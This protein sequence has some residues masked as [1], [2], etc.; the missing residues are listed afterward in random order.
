MRK[1]SAIALAFALLAAPMAMAAESSKCCAKTCAGAS[2]EK[3]KP[4]DCKKSDKCSAEEKA[5]CCD[6]TDAKAEAPKPPTPKS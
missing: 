5:K 2:A 6:K 3:C 1:I 4:E